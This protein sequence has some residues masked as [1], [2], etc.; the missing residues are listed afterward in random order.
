MIMLVGILGFFP[1]PMVKKRLFWLRKGTIQALAAE[2]DKGKRIKDIFLF[3]VW[4]LENK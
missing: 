2:V 4:P 1:L 3:L